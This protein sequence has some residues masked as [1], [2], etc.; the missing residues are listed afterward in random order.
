MKRSRSILLSQMR[1]TAPQL[2]WIVK[3]LTLAVSGAL[4]AG[5]SQP[6]EAILIE[7]VDDCVAK[8]TLN[9]EQ[10]DAA[11]AQAEQEA[12]RTAPR[13]NSQRSC[14]AE[15]GYGQCHQSGGFFLPFM[16]GYLFSSAMDPRFPTTVYRYD[17]PYSNYHNRVMTADGQV[18]GTAGRSSY[19]VNRSVL[20]PKPTVTRTVSRGGFGA[21]ASAKSSWGGKSSGWG[22]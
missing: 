1:K 10:C 15:F 2:G 6:E 20:K 7:S 21:K 22:G 5:C 19:R 9:Q 4:L 16:M 18:I 12:L 11:Y 8:T 14:E 17:R 13:Y 3:P